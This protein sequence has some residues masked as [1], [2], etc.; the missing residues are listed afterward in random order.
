[1]DNRFALQIEIDD[2]P[3]SSLKQLVYSQVVEFKQRHPLQTVL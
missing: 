1:M 3:T 2:L